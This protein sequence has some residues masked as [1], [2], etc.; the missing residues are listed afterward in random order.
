MKKTQKKLLGSLG[1]LVVVAMT[2]FAAYLPG[3]ETSAIETTTLTDVISVR[4]VGEAPYVE[5]TGMPDSIVT[6]YNQRFGVNYEN[7]GAISAKIQYTDESGKTYDAEDLFDG[8][9]VT[10]LPGSLSI[11]NINFKTGEY[12][13]SYQRYNA[14]GEI[15]VVSG[16]TGNLSHFGFGTYRITVQGTGVDGEASEPSVGTITYASVYSETHTVENPDG[17][18]SNYVDLH[19][20]PATQDG[21]DVSSI[22]IVV[23][24]A[25]GNEVFTIGSIPASSDGHSSIELPFDTY[26]LPD[27]NYTIGVY[28]Y[29]ANDEQLGSAYTLEVTYEEDIIYVPDTGDTGGLFNG[30]NISRSDYIITGVMAFG[31]IAI[32]GAAFLIRTNRQKA[33]ATSRGTRVASRTSHS[34]KSK[35]TARNKSGNL[36][37]KKTTKSSTRRR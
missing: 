6:S 11:D 24:D 23:K 32:A 15:E 7:V 37:A 12:T 25:E 18:T 21:G 26:G 27:G 28:V 17:T 5:I 30:L 36:K 19:Y 9:D 33:M 35:S 34:L 22:K 8:L 16:L 4:V 1:L 2:V 10:Y 3:P 20:T 29:G 13:Y 14:E 31:I